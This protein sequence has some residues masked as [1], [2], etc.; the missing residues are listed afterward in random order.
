M[1]QSDPPIS[2]RGGGRGAGGSGSRNAAAIPPQ[3][4]AIIEQHRHTPG[5]LLPMLHGFQDA[6]G[7]VPRE[8]VPLVAEAMNLSQAEVHGVISY[9]HHFRAER[10]GQHVLQICRAESCKACGGDALWEQARTAL[11]CDAHQTSANGQVTLEPVYCLG[12][13]AASPALRMD[14]QVHARVDGR[15]LG[16]LLR[17]AE[18]Q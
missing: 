16:G 5:G 12:L 1:K 7:W 3:Y 18:G 6:L 14:D 17:Q 13:C 10:P 9:Y 4:S 15:M 8:V 11:G 2:N